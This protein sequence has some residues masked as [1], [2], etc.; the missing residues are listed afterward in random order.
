MTPDVVFSSSAA[1]TPIGAR[2]PRILHGANQ[3]RPH[4]QGYLNAAREFAAWCE[5]RGIAALTDVQPARVAAYVKELQGKSVTPTIKQRLAGLRML[6]DWLVTGRIIAVNPAHA[7]RGP[8][9]SVKTG[10]TSCSRPARCV[11]C[12]TQS[13]RIRSSA[14]AI[15]RSST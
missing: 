4:S 9:H 8:K 12:S 1:L 3:Q 2:G 14:C 13:R 5:R 10:K 15:G 7:I 6:F 11:S